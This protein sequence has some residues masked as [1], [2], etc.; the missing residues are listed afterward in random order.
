MKKYWEALS[1]RVLGLSLRERVLVLAALL[2]L[3]WVLADTFVLA[4]LRLKQQAYRQ[5]ITAMQ[6][7]VAKLEAQR[8]DVIQAGQAD[9]DAGNRARL[10]ELQGKLARLESALRET[11]RGLV[12][13]QRMPDVLESLLQRNPQVKLVELATLPV[14]GVL[15]GG[16]QGKTE[17]AATVGIYKH[18]YELTLEGRYFDLMRY[19][20]ALE[21]SP[22]RMLWSGI[23]LQAGE[24][25][26]NTLK[27]T[28]YTLSLD[29]AW[30][31]I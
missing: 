2:A 5:E 7:Q 3:T 14:S 28:L 30:L 25:P 26:K 13:P 10:A 15:E 12:T 9:P 16:A 1:A 27:L 22:W 20:Q 24:Y 8:A 4:P 11:G 21:A 19:V 6:A 29:A 18:G 23:E 31:S 17:D